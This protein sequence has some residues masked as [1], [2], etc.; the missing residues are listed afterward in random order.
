MK[1]NRK[2]IIKQEKRKSESNEIFDT[3]EDFFLGDVNDLN[4]YVSHDNNNYFTKVF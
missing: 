3:Q 2:R 1:K 4:D